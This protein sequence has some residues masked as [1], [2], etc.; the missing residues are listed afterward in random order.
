MAI[1][2]KSSDDLPFTSSS[3]KAVKDTNFVGTQKVR[4]HCQ[5]YSVNFGKAMRAS[6]ITFGLLGIFSTMIIVYPCDFLAL[7]MGMTIVR[8][9][10]LFHDACHGALFSKRSSNQLV[11]SLVGPWLLRTGAGWSDSH[12]HHHKILAQDVP[13]CSFPQRILAGRGPSYD[14]SRTV[15]FSLQEYENMSPLMRLAA[16]FFR[17]PA[18]FFGVVVPLQWPARPSEWTAQVQG[19]AIHFGFYYLGGWAAWVCLAKA[20]WV[21]LVLAGLLFHLQHQVNPGYWKDHDHGHVHD[22]ACLQGCS[23]LEIPWCL[24]WVTLGIEYHHIHHL[25]TRVPC[26][27]LQRCHEECDEKL[28]KDVV[29]VSMWKAFLSCFHTMWDEETERYVS[30][31]LYRMVGLQD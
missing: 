13:P 11:V 2:D 21:A 8:A 28:F 18:I 16:R 1:A 7:I 14:D 17:E 30:F 27:E 23:K 29:S 15:L 26:Y 10:I 25:S 5:R 6:I 20:C 12:N 4:Q 3:A 24:K 9:F 19:L 22:D 31:D